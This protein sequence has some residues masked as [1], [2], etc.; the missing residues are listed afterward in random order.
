MAVNAEELA[1]FLNKKVIFHT[2]NADGSVTEREGK[3]EAASAFGVFFK[4][5]GKSSGD[6]YEPKD[7][8]EIMLV[9]EAPKKIRQKKMKLVEEGQVRQHLVDR[10][11][12]PVS[13]ANE[14]TEEQAV[15]LH[16]R[17]DHTDLGH[18]HEASETTSQEQA[19][20]DAEGDA[21]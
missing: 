16:N 13:K 20:A 9:P 10:H 7:I 17:I 12:M 19:I 21:A 5:K 4:E 14:L 1:Q 8:E 3:V 15:E 11:G 6:L 18:R 2:I